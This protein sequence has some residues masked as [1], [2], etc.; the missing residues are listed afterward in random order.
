MPQELTYTTA[1][2]FLLRHWQPLKPVAT[3][4]CYISHWTKLLIEELCS[5]MNSYQT[6][7][8]SSNQLSAEAFLNLLEAYY[9]YLPCDALTTD[10]W[11]PSSIHSP[12]DCKKAHCKLSRRN[13]GCDP[14]MRTPQLIARV[15]NSAERQIFW[16]FSLQGYEQCFIPTFVLTRQRLNSLLYFSFVW[17]INY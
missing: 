10:W 16:I 8:W 15:L 13:I 5:N 9:S 12:L 1:C 14:A 3:G 17:N 11:I 2:S 6:R 4:I 7:Q